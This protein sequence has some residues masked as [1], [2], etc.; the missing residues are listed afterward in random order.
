MISEIKAELGKNVKIAASVGLE[1]R[2]LK[3]N[4]QKIGLIELKYLNCEI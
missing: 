3:Q 4:G 1:R 2:I